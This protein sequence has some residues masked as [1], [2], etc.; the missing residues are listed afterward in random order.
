MLLGRSREQGR[1]AALLEATRAGHGGALVIRGE[2]G[3]GKTALLTEA[4]A[5][6][7]FTILRARG[8]ET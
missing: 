1:I 5:A 7:G 8:L 3:I 2:V 6:D 4:T